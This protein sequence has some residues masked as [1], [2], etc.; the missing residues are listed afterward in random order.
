[1]WYGRGAINRYDFTDDNRRDTVYATAGYAY[2]MLPYR[3]QRLYLE[4]YQS[5]NTREDAPYFNPSRDRNPGIV[6]RTDF[7]FDTRYKRHVDSLFLSAGA[8]S[9]AGFDTEA[10]WGVRYEQDYDFDDFTSLN[11]GV[12]YGRNYYDGEGENELNGALR[13]VWRF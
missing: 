9:Q 1:V 12:G 8:Y 3:E 4:W 10:R 13:F 6:Q 5:S 7:V 2:E 11:W